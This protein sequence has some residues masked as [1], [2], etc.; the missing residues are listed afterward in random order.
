MY[1]TWLLTHHLYY[2]LFVGLNVKMVV[3]AQLLI[4]APVHQGGQAPPALKVK[5]F[6]SFIDSQLYHFISSAAICTD[7]CINGNCTQPNVCVCEPEWTG[8]VCSQGKR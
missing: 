3:S 2:K 1:L 7:H 4:T 6:S 8:S 5:M